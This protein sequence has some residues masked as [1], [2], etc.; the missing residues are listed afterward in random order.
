MQTKLSQV[1]AAYE[2]G[3]F[4]K[5]LQ[6]CAKFHDLGVHRAAILDAHLAFTNP[7]WMVGL[8]KNLDDCIKNGID[9]LRIRY[10]F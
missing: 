4:K 10:F 9:A 6:I 1:K 5:A 8:G 3:D 7:R 2:K